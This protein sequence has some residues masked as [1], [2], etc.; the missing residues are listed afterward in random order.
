MRIIIE[1]KLLGKENVVEKTSHRVY[2]HFFVYLLHTS[3]R[4]LV[5]MECTFLALTTLLHCDARIR[6]P[7]HPRKPENTSAVLYGCA[8]MM[9]SGLVRLLSDCVS[10]SGV[11]AQGP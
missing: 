9:W 6:R 8:F 4:R 1:G 3:F 10:D 5:S 11:F 2:L 7:E